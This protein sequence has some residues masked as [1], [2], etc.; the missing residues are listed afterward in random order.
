[1]TLCDETPSPTVVPTSFEITPVHSAKDRKDFLDLPYRAYRADPNWRAPL[2]MMQAE[3]ITPAKNP[4]LDRIEHKLFLARQ[5]GQVVGRIAA[6][7]NQAHLSLYD[8]QTGHFGFLDTLAPDPQLVAALLDHAG[9]WMAERG[10]KHMKGP[11]NF[12]INE[13]C[14]LLVDGFDTP[15]MILMPH[16]RPD[17][18]PAV[19]GAGLTKAMD[20][21]AFRYEFQ[22][23][24]KLSPRLER[25]IQTA[26]DF[27]ELTIRP[28]NMRRFKDELAIVLDI[29]NDAW[30]ENWGFI[31]FSEK[32]I[33]TMAK[34]MKPL[35]N[36]QSLWI[37][38]L[39]GEP[40]AFALFLPD[41]N[42]L[43]EGLDG[44]LFPF[45]WAQL[46]NRLKLRGPRRARLPLAGLRRKYHKTKPGMLAAAG[47]FG[48]A[49]RAQY[50]QGVKEIEASWVLET[51]TDLITMCRNYGMDAYKTYR[52]YE[53]AL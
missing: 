31:P 2:R 4:A 53:K 47:S 6:I 46:L 39:Q 9:G 10:M 50:E 23:G 41:L 36:A 49:I 8:D 21:L 13:E 42:E 24:H 48:A 5:N 17:Y 27:P 29:F 37:A 30:S 25:I 19:E 11:F 20:L 26:Q 14:G 12:S 3:Q 44:R 34:E 18:G 43:A 28:M 52:I 22:N 16:G 38:E 33:E 15:P 7:I 40:A 32:Q 51:N 35:L 45:G 1:M